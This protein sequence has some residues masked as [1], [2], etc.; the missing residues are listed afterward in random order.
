M[1][2]SPL[3]SYAHSATPEAAR[4]GGADAPLGGH[5]FTLNGS[6]AAG[7]KQGLK[8]VS[9]PPPSTRRTPLSVEERIARNEAKLR[10]ISR[11]FR[12]DTIT[13]PNA[14]QRAALANASMGDSVY[15]EDEDTRALEEWVAE[16][17]GMEA[18]LFCSSGTMTNQL[19]IR[20]HLWQP[21]HSVVTDAR[22]HVHM[23]EAGGIASHSFAS[24]NS[25]HAANG[26]HMTVEEVLDNCVI[27]DDVH[28]APTRLVCVENTLS[29]MIFPQDEL[30][31]LRRALDD[32]DI[33]LHCDGARM[34]E[35]LAATGMSL[36]EACAPFH[37]VSLCLSKG[38][39]AP[40]GSILA[41]P[42]DFIKRAN[43][44]RKAFGGGVRQCGS[45][46]LA[47]TLALETI[48][49]QLPRT[50]ALAR[51]LSLGL[52][53]AGLALDL[54][55]ETQMVWIDPAPIGITM[56]QLK[57]AARERKAITVW[58][59]RGRLVV[60]HQIDPQAVEDLIELVRELRDENVE[61]AKAWE[62]RTGAKRA[63]EIRARSR[64]YAEGRWEGRIE[65][66]P[67]RL[68]AYSKE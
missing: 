28:T 53:E 50:H 46:A 21:P 5:A 12:T 59:P 51:R 34:W 60:H 33:K 6:R 65:G 54:P 67:K 64:M 61:G 14:E 63:Q 31:R 45:T 2:L 29:G 58:E 7:L 24:V 20:T 9:L 39:G 23:L 8:Q 56:K 10:S 18:A 22:A 13:V 43:W 30:V 27:G 32:F 16:L 49:P 42:A 40:I 25:V 62:E 3:R 47:A 35:V 48:F 11:D 36:K 41:G 19:G 66:P 15:G 55:T 4:N 38:V 44:H 68:P 52:V 57:A 26:H 17:T 37:S 1:A